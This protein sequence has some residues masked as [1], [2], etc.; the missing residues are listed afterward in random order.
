MAEEKINDLEWIIEIGWRRKW[1]ILGTFA[2]IFTL[3][4]LWALYLPNIYRSSVSIYIEPQGVPLDYVRPTVTSD[5]ENRLRSIK[6]QIT[7]R[8]KLLN[9][10]KKLELYPDAV[11]KGS[12]DEVLVAMM[13]E[14]LSIEAPDIRGDNFYIIHFNHKDPQKAMLAVSDLVSLFIQESLRVRER[15]ATGTTAFIEDELEKLKQTLEDQEKAVQQY[16]K[17]YMGELPDQLEANL[18]MLDNLQLQITNNR[19]NQRALDGQAMLLEQDISRLEGEL[20]VASSLSDS[21]GTLMP[22]NATLNQLLAQREALQTR[23]T[24]M[25]SMYT[26]RHPDLVAAKKEL[27]RLDNTLRAITK[28]LEKTGSPKSSAIL[29]QLTGF[30]MELSNLRRQLKEVKP[31]L[32]SL[33]Q[34]EKE[35]KARMK[36]YQERVESAPV[37]EQQLAKLTRDYENTKTNYEELLNK[38]MEAQMSE[39][40]EKRQQGEKFQILDQANYPEKPFLPKRGRIIAIGSVGGMGSGIGLALLLEALFPAF[41][42]LKQLQRHT[43]GIP[44]TFGILDMY[45]EKEQQLR[46]E[47]AVVVFF[48]SAGAATLFLLIIDKFLI[49]LGSI[50]KVIGS[51]VRG[52]LS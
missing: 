46:W 19:E 47:K 31:R 24:T 32:N 4:F 14:D 30:T 16:K 26:E 50:V 20:D 22:T 21:D 33:R 2:A 13:R 11:K 8:T 28:D 41:Y 51:N 49:D 34:E 38:K 44:I 3:V 29:P 5:I 9:V 27:A 12:P 35:L 43:P 48:I 42:S 17:T 18:R 7:S 1:V 45:S 40:L 36:E 37:R 39:N 25:E 6:Q 15:Q 10:I 23:V 52:I